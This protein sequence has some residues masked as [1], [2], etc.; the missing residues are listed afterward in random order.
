MGV[1]ACAWYSVHKSV[2][3]PEALSIFPFKIT[4]T[5]ADF[6]GPVSAFI[7]VCV[8][9]CVCACVCRG[10]VRVC[11]GVCVGVC[12]ALSVS[13]SRVR[14]CVSALSVPVSLSPCLTFRH[15]HVSV[16]GH[17]TTQPTQPCTGAITGATTAI[18]DTTTTD[19]VLTTTGAECMFKFRPNFVKLL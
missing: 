7:C 11:V 13:V 19:T 14:V 6:V 17:Q 5:V 18:T 10:C 12:V 4:R 9:V 1:A 8:S 15:A 2:R 3:C 16:T